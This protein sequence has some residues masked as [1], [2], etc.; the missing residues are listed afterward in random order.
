MSA[1][2]FQMLEN[3][4]TWAWLKAKTD[5]AHARAVKQL[6]KIRRERRRLAR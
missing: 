1:A 5:R 2:E 4:F 6:R 3:A